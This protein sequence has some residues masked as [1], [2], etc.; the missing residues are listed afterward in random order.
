MKRENGELKRKATTLRI[1][2]TSF[3]GSSPNLLNVFVQLKQFLPRKL[4]F[5]LA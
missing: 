5:A 3:F 4:Y 1:A 2:W